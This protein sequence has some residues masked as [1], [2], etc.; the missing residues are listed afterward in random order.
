M[1]LLQEMDVKLS[2]ARIHRNKLIYAENTG[3]VDISHAVKLYVR[4]RFGYNSKQFLLISKI[5]FSKSV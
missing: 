4:G 3:L 2:A 5:H 1:K